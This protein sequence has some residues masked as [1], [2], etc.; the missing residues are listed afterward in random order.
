MTVMSDLSPKKAAARMLLQ[1][2]FIESVAIIV[3]ILAYAFT[4]QWALLAAGVLLGTGLSLPAIIS[5]IRA[6]MEERNRA[7]R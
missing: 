1:A 4:G 2:A 3:G 5:F 7:S 6:S